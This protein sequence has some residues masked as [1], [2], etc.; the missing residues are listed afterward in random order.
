MSLNLC[1]NS[2]SNGSLKN[3]YLKKILKKVD[4]VFLFCATV[5]LGN[6]LLAQLKRDYPEILEQVLLVKFY[7]N[8]TASLNKNSFPRLPLR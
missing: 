2:L 5:V 6:N 8:E 7:L 3:G 1:L 4:L